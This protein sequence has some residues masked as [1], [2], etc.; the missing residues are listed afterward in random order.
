M[1]WKGIRNSWSLADI[2]VYQ[3]CLTGCSLGG[4]STLI[5]GLK[6]F[7]R[8]GDSWPRFWPA[9]VSWSFKVSNWNSPWIPKCT[10][11]IKQIYYKCSLLIM[12]AASLRLNK[13][14]AYGAKAVVWFW[15]QCYKAGK[16]MTDFH[17][18]AV[19]LHQCTWSSPSLLYLSSCDTWT[20]RYH[21]FPC[22]ILKEL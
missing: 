1:C 5:P 13:N 20:W 8:A 11:K 4:C 19:N 14:Q 21:V 17:R 12:L 10:A 6:S 3:P 2:P 9:L 15:L 16:K 7:Q 18:I 22:L